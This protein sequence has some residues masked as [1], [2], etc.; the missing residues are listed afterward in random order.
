MPSAQSKKFASIPTATG[1]I[2]RLAC[3]RM[4]ELGKDPGA[5]LSR[6]GLTLE[7]ADDPTARLEVRTQIKILELIAEEL[8]DELL[9]FRLAL[10]FD[11]REIGLVY[12]VMAS[13]ELLADA[14]RNA[15]RYSGIVNEGVRLYLGLDRTTAILLDYVNVDRR[16]DRH[17]ME[18]LLVA[19]VRICRQLTDSR[20]AVRQLKVRHSR[21]NIPEE[22]KSFFAGDIQFG[23]DVDEIA[24][25]TP[26]ASLKIV[27]RDTYL[28]SLLR[29]YAEEALVDKT[30]KRPGI[31]G[32]VQETIS[33]LLPHGRAEASEVARQLGMSSR[34]L[35]RKLR[36]EGEAFAGILNE[37]RTALA[38][39]Y[40]RDHE[41]TVTEITWLLGYREV[42]SFTHAFKRWT[43]MTP[44][45][46]RSSS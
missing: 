19:L 44:R 42:S 38:K 4:R 2:A 26:V 17:Q 43:G 32:D 13:S 15:E 12:Y 24:F 7:E 11:L 22:F 36:D 37:L 35:S 6:A 8:Q 30:A 18:F 27:G 34:T 39:R 46:F 28:N 25:P 3:T 23:A 21:A 33:Q 20:L 45:Q 31:R 1:G 41:F 14:L 5:V 29:R 10:T 40:L 16:L 9:G